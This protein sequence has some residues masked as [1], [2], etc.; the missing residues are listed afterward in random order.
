MNFENPLKIASITELLAA[1]LRVVIIMSTPIVIFFLILAGFN[2]VTARG[3]P[4]KIASASRSLMYGVI[5]GVI[6]LS[7]IAI[8]HIVQSVVSAF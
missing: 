1:I 2:Y 4:E 6:I 7:S 3:N 5:G 8:I